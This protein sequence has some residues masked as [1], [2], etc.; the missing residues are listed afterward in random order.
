MKSSTVGKGNMLEVIR[1]VLRSET[2]YLASTVHDHERR[3]YEDQKLADLV[4]VTL[5]SPASVRRIGD[6]RLIVVPCCG[7]RVARPSADGVATPCWTSSRPTDPGLFA[8]NT[9]NGNLQLQYTVVN[10]FSA[11]TDIVDC[12]MHLASAW[13]STRPSIP[14][15][16]VNEC[17]LWL[18]KQRQVWLIPIADERVGVH[19]KLDRVMHKWAI[20]QKPTF[21]ES[22]SVRQKTRISAWG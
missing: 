1:L 21:Q 20:K 12:A 8:C 2:V 4:Y 16:S 13:R 18:G 9:V 19:V 22:L 5:S 3:W 14:P 15:C 6:D 10:S 17:Q 7:G 11:I